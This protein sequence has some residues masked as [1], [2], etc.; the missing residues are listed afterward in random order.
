MKRNTAIL[1][2][3]LLAAVSVAAFVF[4]FP[5]GGPALP[6]TS[7]MDDAPKPAH[8]QQDR[9]EKT[10][11]KEEEA[12]RGTHPMDPL[13]ASMTREEQVAQLF[14]VRCPDEGAAEL[15]QT[16][17]PA[18]YVLFGRDFENKSRE[19]VAQTVQSYQAAAKI[20]LLI[21]TDEEGGTV[22]RASANRALRRWPFESPQRVYERGGLHEVEADTA[23]KDRFLQGLGVNVNLAPVADVSTDAKDFIYPRTMGKGAQETA[24]YVGVVVRTMKND[25][26]GTV[27]KHFP[28]YGSNG[29]THAGTVTDTRPAERFH[30]ADFLPFRAGIRQGADAVLVSHTIVQVFDA[31]HPASLSPNIHQILREELGFQGVIVTDDL[32]ME[33]LALPEGEAAVQAVQAGNDL[34][35]SS[36]FAVQYQAVL[37]AVNQGQISENTLYHALRRVLQWKS[38]LGLL[39]A[40]A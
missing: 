21:G 5:A 19:E 29:D 25:G 34:L 32:A 20:P 8:T 18:G 31:A 37:N 17:Q 23:E 9:V 12:A 28:G 15:V 7:I 39:Q 35:L 33:A 3:A 4:I 11:P 14:W 22:V 27:L 26:M 10:E 6:G 1:C 38:D 24:D 36:N 30:E 2:A 13:I 16:Y 40:E